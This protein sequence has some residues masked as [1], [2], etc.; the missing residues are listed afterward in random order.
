M[1]NNSAPQILNLNFV[2]TVKAFTSKIENRWVV[3][4]LTKEMFD[5]TDFWNY[6]SSYVKEENVD[7]FIEVAATKNISVIIHR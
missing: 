3:M 2:P 4:N 7:K 1:E 6:G 5:Y